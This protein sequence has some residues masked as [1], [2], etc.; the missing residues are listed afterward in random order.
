MNNFF[1]HLIENKSLLYGILTGVLSVTCTLLSIINGLSLIR[2]RRI[3]LSVSFGLGFTIDGKGLMNFYSPTKE[4]F[5]NLSEAVSAGVCI[6]PSVSIINHSKYTIF[7]DEIGLSWEK[8]LKKKRAIL[9][10]DRI[11]SENKNT[12]RKLKIEPYASICLTFDYDSLTF[13]KNIK[14]VYVETADQRRFFKNIK[15]FLAT[16]Y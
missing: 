9:S 3:K 15:K 1:S 11:I 7:I 8:N 2:E 5:Y 12:E 16:E 14:Y 6:L 10:F 13:D 4:C